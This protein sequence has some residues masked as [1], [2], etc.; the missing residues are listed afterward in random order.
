MNLRK[1]R[2]LNPSS[3]HLRELFDKNKRYSRT[4]R[5]TIQV[6]SVTLKEDTEDDL[7]EAFLIFLRSD[8]SMECVQPAEAVEQ[9]DLQRRSERRRGSKD[10]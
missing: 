1:L 2:E 6:G 9:D 3:T 7:W 5:Y 8:T 10:N 4:S